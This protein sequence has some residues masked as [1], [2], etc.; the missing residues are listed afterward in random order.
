MFK[1]REMLALR[2]Q[3]S[4]QHCCMTCLPQTSSRNGCDC[5]VGGMVT[6]F[7]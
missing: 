5:G 3:P 1:F 7:R 2:L 6:S 4:R